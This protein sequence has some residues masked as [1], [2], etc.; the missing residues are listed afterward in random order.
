M[1]PLPERRSGPFRLTF[2]SGK[3]PYEFVPVFEMVLEA[4]SSFSHHILAAERGL[5][6]RS[7]DSHMRS[8]LQ[9]GEDTHTLTWVHDARPSR[10][11]TR[12][13]SAPGKKQV[14]RRHVRI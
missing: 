12:L 10:G 7:F 9:C 2:T 5:N 1:I 8:K 11:V 3:H 13:H 4:L 14:W 6:C